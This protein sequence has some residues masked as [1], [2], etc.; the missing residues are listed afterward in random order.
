MRWF[1]NNRLKYRNSFLCNTEN[2][3][4]T[5]NIIYHTLPLP[6]TQLVFFRFLTHD[7]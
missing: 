2:N 1:T 6:S 4:L 3:P 7:K 5:I